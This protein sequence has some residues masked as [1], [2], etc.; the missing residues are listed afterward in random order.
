MTLVDLIGA[1]VFVVYGVLGIYTGTI[2]RVLGLIVIYAA[3]W[4][5]TNMGQPGGSIYIQY[6]PTTPVPDARLIGWIFF[7]VLLM[8]ALEGAATA[9]NAQLQLAVVAWNRAVGFVIGLVTALV[10][11]IAVFYMV[12]GYSKANTNTPSDL[13]I[14]TR[15]ALVNSHFVFPLVKAT[16][17]PILPLLSAV[18][19]RD[20]TAYF[21]FSAPK[22]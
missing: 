16:A 15:D 1:L 19:P 5:A 4:V 11:V 18:L 7:L 9:V 21:S 2:R 3:M 13:Q 14:S 8:L 17:A 6:A 22:P 20:S 10:L 12:A